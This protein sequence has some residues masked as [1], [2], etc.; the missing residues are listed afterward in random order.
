MRVRVARWSSRVRKDRTGWPLSSLRREALRV[1]ATERAAGATGS[2]RA[3]GCWS[4]N[5]NGPGFCAGARS[6]RRRASR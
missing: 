6:G 1:A 2:V 4:V 5:V 3:G